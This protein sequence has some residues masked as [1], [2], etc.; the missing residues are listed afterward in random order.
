MKLSHWEYLDLF[1]SFHKA[2]A[3]LL[4]SSAERQGIA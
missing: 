1:V 2:D 4:C 3:F